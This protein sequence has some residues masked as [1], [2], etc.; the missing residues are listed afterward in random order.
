MDDDIM[1]KSDELRTNNTHLFM[2]LQN[3][4]DGPYSHEIWDNSRGTIKANMMVY[5]LGAGDRQWGQNIEVRQ[6]QNR[7]PDLDGQ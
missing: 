1:V 4:N 5:F 3:I 2:I 7:G 6:M